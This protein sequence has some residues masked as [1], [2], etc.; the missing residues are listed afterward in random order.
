MNLT[1]SEVVALIDAERSRLTEKHE[2]ETDAL[3][4]EIAK[5][6]KQLY[7]EL[8]PEQKDMRDLED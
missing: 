2:R 4:A 7:G 5:L 3:Y 8:P 6:K 1:E